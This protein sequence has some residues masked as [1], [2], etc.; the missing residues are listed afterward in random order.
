MPSTHFPTV[1][2]SQALPTP[3]MSRAPSS[4]AGG[5][6]RYGSLRHV[7]NHPYRGGMF[8]GTLRNGLPYEGTVRDVDII[9]RRFS[10]Q[11]SDGALVN[12]GRPR[13]L[14]PGAVTPFQRLLS[15]R[16]T[17]FQRGEPGAEHSAGDEA[18]RRRVLGCDPS[19]TPLSTQQK[20]D[21]N[22]DPCRR[23][24]D[25]V[26]ARHL[27][28]HTFQQH[29]EVLRR[30]SD[31]L[32]AFYREDLLADAYADWTSACRGQYTGRDG[33]LQQLSIQSGRAREAVAALPLEQAQKDVCLD[34]YLRRYLTYL[35]DETQAYREDHPKGI[36]KSKSNP[37]YFKRGRLDGDFAIRD[38]LNMGIL[39]NVDPCPADL[40]FAGHPRRMPG[41]A[42]GLYTR[43]PD[44]LH[45]AGPEAPVDSDPDSWLSYNFLSG[46]T[47]FVNGLSGSM[48]VEIGG[49]VYARTRMNGVG[50]LAAT[51]P[52][53]VVE[54]YFRALA[55]MYVYIDGGH[56]LFEIQ[57]SF[58]Q[59]WVAPSLVKAF[60][61]VRWG[62]M[63]QDL[64]A[65][66]PAFSSAWR[67]TQRHAAVLQQQR[68]VNDE[69]TQRTA[70]DARRLPLA[71]RQ[72]HAA[73]GLLHSPGPALGK[74]LG[75]AAGRLHE[76][77]QQ[78]NENVRA[79]I[80]SHLTAEQ[81][82]LAGQDAVAV[83][84]AV[85]RVADSS[86]DASRCTATDRAVVLALMGDIGGLLTTPSNGSLALHEGLRRALHAAGLEVPDSERIA[87]LRSVGG[88]AA[89]GPRKRAERTLIRHAAG[90]PRMPRAGVQNT[91][92]RADEALGI[93]MPQRIAANSWARF[94]LSAE[95]TDAMREPMVGHMSASP[96][97]ILQVWDML[98]GEPAQQQFVAGVAGDMETAPLTRTT[99]REARAAGC[100]AFLL[101]LGYHS[102]V[103]VLEGV[104]LHGGQSLRGP[105]LIEGDQDAGHLFGQGAATDIIV[106]LIDNHR[107]W[108]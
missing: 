8:T 13:T 64:F 22:N 51:A 65:D 27:L 108:D 105:G 62:T 73:R 44:R 33:R 70:H 10:G 99:A 86:D 63:G 94:R 98:R 31:S 28:V 35:V 46:V 52:P 85:G 103:E 66:V 69:L 67:E 97:E 76:V 87:T 17:P 29:G 5:T 88:S 68:M 59:T 55:G 6:P 39:R 82:L 79:E 80:S 75:A 4:P 100:A 104:L 43:C 42:E 32:L 57:S 72:S 45:M 2:M 40:R 54:A 20:H 71:L 26:F 23:F 21:V 18:L 93:P 95:R 90:T 30:Y 61:D 1:S 19:F 37:L 102:A 41:I 49:L 96:A 58:R 16:D 3:S 83:C 77:L 84:E 92:Q 47:P 81:R 9:Y 60:E 24:F 56:S 106:G 50:G 107:S 101:G 25:T 12:Q 34:L 53:E 91:G 7:S 89:V 38:S 74:E 14:R 15:Q 36:I 78:M 11:V 48:L